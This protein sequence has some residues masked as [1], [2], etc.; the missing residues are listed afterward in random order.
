M[1]NFPTFTL[2]DII[3]RWNALPSLPTPPFDGLEGGTTKLSAALAANTK[4]S[5]TVLSSSCF[6]YSHIIG[7]A[8][9][10]LL[11]STMA[12]NTSEQDVRLRSKEGVASALLELTRLPV[13]SV[14]EE[15][16]HLRHEL[17]DWNIRAQDIMSASAISKISYSQIE[18]LYRQ[19]MS[20]LAL[21]TDRRSEL[22]HNIKPCTMIEGQIK[23]FAAS[24][25]NLV[26]PATS[27]WARTQFNKS[28]KWIESYSDVMEIIN[29]HGSNSGPGVS[30][31]SPLQ[32]FPS[33]GRLVEVQRIRN[34]VSEHSELA[35]AF[36]TNY[37]QLQS[38][39][40]AATQWETM[41]DRVLAT[42]TLTLNER[43][44][45]LAVASQSRPRGIMLDPSCDA[46]DEWRKL[47]TWPL[48]L[49]RGIGELT[50]KL[51]SRT[52]SAQLP[53]EGV[54]IELMSLVNDSL[55]QLI[56]A[57]RDLFQTTTKFLGELK[58]QVLCSFPSTGQSVKPDAILRTSKYG[59][60]VLG[61][62][63][64]DSGGS[65]K[66]ATSVFWKL[67]YDK[68]FDHLAKGGSSGSFA[69]S[70]DLS[71]AKALISLCPIASKSP[72]DTS[73][74]L[75]KLNE[76]VSDAERLQNEFSL[77]IAQ[78]STFLQANCFENEARI[79]TCLSKL[80][81]LQSDFEDP[82]RSLAVILLRHMKC[83]DSLATKI[84][85]LAWLED[86][87]AHGGV[88]DDNVPASDVGG[89]IH[90]REL[91]K[92]HD[93]MPLAIDFDHTAPVGCAADGELLRMSIHVKRT[94]DRARL[95]Q[96][97]VGAV[98]KDT[99]S[100]DDVI[101]LDDLTA[102]AVD[103]ILSKVRT[104]LVSSCALLD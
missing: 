89:R 3:E 92:L 16:L 100:G 39:Q 52:A 24:E 84:G 26:C 20:I 15:K 65:V 23:L 48:D 37:A 57:G 45:Q 36:Q 69:N 6:S 73:A 99:N 10:R 34:L 5:I 66:A 14:V 2:Q 54:E 58:T 9:A 19:L 91:K 17:L 71:D 61:I 81:D 33:T 28:S 63:H 41:I 97:R 4:D 64:S 21:Q 101:T 44:Q 46:I 31:L 62:I 77:G 55:G 59:P 74:D 87:L 95:W 85:K 56:V 86:V 72:I 80:K 90:I 82:E 27:A 8:E 29:S 22:C 51:L 103:P 47:L 96:Q 35:C 76:I 93:S 40:Q 50:S 11:S 13:L 43:C 102:I 94:F 42:D 32:L 18:N 75:L 79:R 53:G 30:P 104:V 88:F 12:D 70:C 1:I 25:E 38:I 78:A 68:F 49:E 67:L 98:L 60:K 7:N 83:E